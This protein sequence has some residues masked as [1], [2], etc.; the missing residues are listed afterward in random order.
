MRKLLLIGLLGVSAC[1]EQTQSGMSEADSRALG[2]E[3]IAENPELLRSPVIL[4]ALENQGLAEGDSVE[5]VA[6]ISCTMANL[7]DEEVRILAAEADSASGEITG[8]AVA[9]M[10]PAMFRAETQACIPGK[11]REIEART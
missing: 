2:G 3:L 11:M 7:T 9:A 6:T 4:T 8:E 10:L 1:A 5:K